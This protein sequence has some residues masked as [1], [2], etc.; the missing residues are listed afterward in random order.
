MTMFVAYA[1]NTNRGAQQ[2]L[3][4]R[5][6]QIDE[7]MARQR[8]EAEALAREEAELEARKLAIRIEV[9]R[10]ARQDAGGIAPRT[11]RITTIVARICRATGVSRNDI[12]APRRSV[13]IVLARQAI[14]YWAYRL[15]TLSTPQIGRRL[16]NRDHTT[17]LHAV[18]IYPSK[19]AKMGRTLRKAR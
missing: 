1:E 11:V 17:V 16:G 7:R 15:T 13:R 12:M 18:H 4:R 14:M 10:L 5:Q 8:A 6:Q 2:A 19:R 3:L 9:A